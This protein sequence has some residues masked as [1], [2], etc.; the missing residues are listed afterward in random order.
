MPCT[1]PPP[2][3]VA[4]IIQV[5]VAA[6]YKLTFTADPTSP[7]SANYLQSAAGD[8]DFS[9]FPGAVKVRLT[10][11]T[12]GIAFYKSL[13]K[14]SLSFASN[15]T[16]PKQPLHHGNPEFPGNVQHSGAQ[17]IW[18]N[19]KNAKDCGIPNHPLTCLKSAYGI[20]LWN[21]SG[22]YLAEKDPIIQNGGSSSLGH[23]HGRHHRHAR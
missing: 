5:D 20:Y 17:S 10:I 9:C 13:T 18:F 2:P 15:S 4:A 14:D 21:L 16:Q 11:Q 1:A 19:Y 6:N 3:Q 7:G 8:W 12:N 22:G 23:G